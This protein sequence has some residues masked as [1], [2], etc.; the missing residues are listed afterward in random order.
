MPNRHK[1]QN[2][3]KVVQVDG[4][5]GEEEEEENEAFDKYYQ[6]MTSASTLVCSLV[7]L[8]PCPY[9]WVHIL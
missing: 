6:L 5:L 9:L 1:I 4:V 8:L 7:L 2:R 3:A